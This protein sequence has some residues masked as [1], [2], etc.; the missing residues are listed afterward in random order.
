MGWRQFPYPRNAYIHTPASLEQAWPRLHRGDAQAFPADAALVQAW[1][2]FHAGDF[3]LAAKLGL[4][5]GP[6][7]Y[8]VAH[9]AACVHA[10]CI[11]TSDRAKFAA[12][13][14]VARRCERQQIEQPDNP[15]AYYWHAYSLGRYA[16]GISIVKALSQ[17]IGAKV[18][19]SLEKTLLLQPAHAD[20]HIAFG[21]YHAEIIDKVGPLMGSLT[22][23]A[24]KEDGLR[25]FQR[26]I[27]LNPETAIGR[28]EYANALLLLEGKKKMAEALTLYQQAAACA[29]LD[30]MERLHVEAALDEL[31]DYQ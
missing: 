31:K 7:G 15:A 28:I 9:K 26:A 2:A 21:I 10:A 29:A 3:E 30:A 17:G 16:Q 5:A 1:I 11:E 18:Y 6:D 20:G 22:Y 27:T 23:G 19:N 8:G 4:A 25:H 24:R 14:E 12:F 13:E